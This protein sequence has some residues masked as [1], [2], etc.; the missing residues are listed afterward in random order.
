MRIRRD[1]RGLAVTASGC[2]EPSAAKLRNVEAAKYR[3][4]SVDT[5]V[6]ET[7]RAK[8]EGVSRFISIL[9]LF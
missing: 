1:L 9:Y 5:V 4:D 7:R 2:C 8:S 3:V 6:R